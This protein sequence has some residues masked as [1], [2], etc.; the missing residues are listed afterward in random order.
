MPSLNAATCQRIHRLFE[1]FKARIADW[2][3]VLPGL[4][5]A[6]RQL[7]QD[8]GEPDYAIETPIVYNR[9]LDRLAAGH[10]IRWLLIADNPGKTEQLASQNRYLVGSSGRMAENFF[11][12]RL[13]I[14]F[15]SQVLIINKTPVHTPK[16]QQLRRLIVLY[17]ALG[18]VFTESQHF[19][20]SLAWQLH[21]L[22]AAPIWLMGL[23][24]LKPRGLFS[25]WRETF[26][27]GMPVDPAVY[28]FNHFS[29]GSFAADYKRRKLPDETAL[30]A[31]LRIG[32]ENRSKYFAAPHSS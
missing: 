13:D 18:R 14:D 29:M 10:D 19:M 6:Q 12:Q 24:E 11:R 1:Q 7:H 16:T 2:N 31:V 4:A 26:G 15:R 9:D 28:V 8:C 17:P 23:S 25:A 5:D 3:A 27:A 30:Q 22:T 21:T 20:A 32:A